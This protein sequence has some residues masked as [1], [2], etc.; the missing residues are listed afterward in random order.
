MSTTSEWFVV[1]CGDVPRAQ[2]EEHTRRITNHVGVLNVT[3]DQSWS[4]LIITW[5]N[6]FVSNVYTIKKVQNLY[7]IA[8][9]RLLV[10]I[11]TA[12][13]SLITAVVAFHTPSWRVGEHAEQGQA[14]KNM[15][16]FNAGRVICCNYH[17]HIWGLFSE[18]SVAGLSIIT[19]NHNNAGVKMAAGLQSPLWY[20]R[21]LDT[22]SRNFTH[23]D[24]ET[25]AVLCSKSMQ[26]CYDIL[27]VIKLKQD[28]P[29]PALVILSASSHLYGHNSFSGATAL[30]SIML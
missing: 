7:Q 18:V 13:I 24:R 3:T 22:E 17:K 26:S 21:L 8:W 29:A 1:W 9:G 16:P 30:K 4:I 12:C 6:N 28:F 2:L 25:T 5:N 19:I 20:M 23:P 10:D 15:W 11:L 27:K 14:C